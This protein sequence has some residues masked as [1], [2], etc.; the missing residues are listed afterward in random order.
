MQ[1][2]LRRAYVTAQPAGSYQRLFGDDDGGRVGIARY[3]IRHE[4]SATA[5]LRSREG[6]A[7]ATG[8]L[9]SISENDG[10]IR[11]NAVIPAG[12]RSVG[13]KIDAINAPCDAAQLSGETS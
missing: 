2:P 12:T 13:E 6:A 4:A 1:T 3:E 9:A 10:A 7:G 8:E 5:G 11:A